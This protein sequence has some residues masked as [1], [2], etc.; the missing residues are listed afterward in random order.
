MKLI[1]L[2]LVLSVSALAQVA[3]VTLEYVEKLDNGHIIKIDGV[4]YLAV[5]VVKA[6]ELLAYKLTS[7]ALQVQLE[8]SKKKFSEFKAT[9][10]SLMASEREKSALLLTRQKAESDFYKKEYE[11]ELQLRQTFETSLRKCGKPWFFGYRLCKF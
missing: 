3:P 4:N 11:D 8:D 1:L 7:E 9:S 5:D 2:I 6:K 10:E